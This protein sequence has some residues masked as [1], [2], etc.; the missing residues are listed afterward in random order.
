M[1]RFCDIVS[2]LWTY[3]IAKN[4]ISHIRTPLDGVI[5]CYMRVM[6]T[7]KHEQITTTLIGGLNIQNQ[8]LRQ[9]R[10]RGGYSPPVG[11]C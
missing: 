10:A 5:I 4:A 1:K 8:G 9:G 7:M 6:G 3:T 11:A 2:Y